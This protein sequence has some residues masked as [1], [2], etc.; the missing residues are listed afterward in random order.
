MY[1]TYIRWSSSRDNGFGD[2]EEEEEE[3]EEEELEEE[4]EEEVESIKNTES[5]EFEKCCRL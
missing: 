2:M 5:W 4:V 1:M 3:E